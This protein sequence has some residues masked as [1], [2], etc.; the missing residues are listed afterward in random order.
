MPT[1]I[2]ASTLNLGQVQDFLHL[3]NHFNSSI[4]AYLTLEEISEVEHQRLSEIRNLAEIYLRDGNILEGQI[5]FLFL[6]PLLWL[7]GFYHPNLK[8]TLEEGI[9]QIEIEDE[10]MVI[11]GR[12]DILAAERT[13]KPSLSPIASPTALWILLIESKKAGADISVGY[14]QLLTYAYSVLGKQ[15]SVW[16]LVTNGITYQ[17]LYLQQGKPSSIYQLFPPLNFL[18]TEQSVQLLQIL[19]AICEL[20]IKEQKN[21]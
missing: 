9:E 3:E 12:M 13:T 14:P 10:N 2:D 17:F 20:G 8:I 19:K 5:K 11:K 7:S 16:G 4:L 21:Y 6:S 15:D 18:Y 1:T